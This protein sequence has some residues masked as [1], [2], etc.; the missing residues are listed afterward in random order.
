MN[1][2]K[3]VD[4]FQKN[5]ESDYEDPM[6]HN[7]T[8][9]NLLDQTQLD[10]SAMG[11]MKSEFTTEV[12]KMETVP[13]VLFEDSANDTNEEEMD[14]NDEDNKDG[15]KGTMFKILDCMPNLNNIE[16]VKVEEQPQIE[17]KNDVQESQN[18]LSDVF[19]DGNLK[20]DID[21]ISE[22][23]ESPM[24]ID[25]SQLDESTDTASEAMAEIKHVKEP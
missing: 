17:I 18:D 5:S 19:Y 13:S 2:F 10:L 21:K 25:D 14:Y 12:P 3:L 4:F 8:I 1:S 15:D 7:S 24:E 16:N 22:G 6:E 20:S 9:P 23:I 11:N